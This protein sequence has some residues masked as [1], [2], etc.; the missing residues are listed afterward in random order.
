[1]FSSTHREGPATGP[2]SVAEELPGIFSST[3]R[4]GPVEVPLGVID[5]MTRFIEESTPSDKT[6]KLKNYTVKT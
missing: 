6:F 1:M 5:S 4:E 3:L 2:W